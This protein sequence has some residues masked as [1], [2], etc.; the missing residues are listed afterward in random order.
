MISV[1]RRLLPVV[2]KELATAVSPS[3]TTQ[4]ITGTG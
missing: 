2:L 4:L 3:A 1:R